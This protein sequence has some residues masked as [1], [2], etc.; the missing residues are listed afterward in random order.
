MVQIFHAIQAL[1]STVLFSDII[2]DYL[3]PFLLRIVT[4]HFSY[5]HY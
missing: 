3:T 4:P 5:F 1:L 2:Y